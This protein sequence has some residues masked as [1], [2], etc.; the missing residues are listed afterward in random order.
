MDFTLVQYSKLLCTLREAGYS[1]QPFREFLAE[2]RISAIILR[3]DVDKK[4]G[5]SLRFAKSQAQRGIR[6]TYYFR[7]LPCSFDEGIIRE[8]HALGHEIGY[9]YEDVALEKGNMEK[10]YESF[11]RNLGK[12]RS[13][14][15]VETICM[16]G[17]PLSRYDNRSLWDH[18]SYKDLGISGEPYFDV[19]FEKVLYLTDTGR[20]WDGS[21][22]SVRDKS[23]TAGKNAFPGLRYHSTR[24]I[25]VAC[26]EGKL[27]DQVMYTFHPQRWTDNFL[28]GSG[29]FLLQN[30]KN[31]AKRIL[32]KIR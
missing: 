1:F 17:S 8:I 5:H 23:M 22:V 21:E 15:P 7:I 16:H 26:R 32:M 19:N 11:R 31:I 30:L 12:I 14:V 28:E 9:H 18:Y 20:R 27:P 13:I 29:E 10:A 2:Q 24:H 3:H 25:M 6:G 4:P